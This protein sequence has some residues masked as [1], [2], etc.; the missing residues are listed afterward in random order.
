MKTFITDD[1]LLYNDTARELFHDTAKHLPI[2]DYHNHLNQHEIL[3]DKNYNNIAEIWLGEDHYKWRAMR[4]NGIDE[5]Y[6]TGDKSDYDKF[7]A[8][9][10]TVPMAFGNPLYHWT[11]LELL[12]YFE[13]AELLDEKS[14]PAIWEEA[15]QKLAT[16]EMSVRSLLK[17]MNVEFVGTTDDPVDDLASHKKLHDE[18]FEITVSPSF[19]PDKGINIERDEYL[20]WLDQLREVTNSS[21]D[22]YDQFLAAL[23]ERVD[24]FDEHGCR[25]SDHGIEVIFYAEATKNEVEAIFQK[26][27][28]GEALTPQ[29]IE[30]YKTYTLVSLGEM[31]A[32]KGW[33]MQL[34]MSPLRNNNTR[35]FS[36]IGPDTGF[37]SIG[38]VR[39]AEKLANLLDALDAKDKLPKT[40]LYS[41]N[42]NDNDVLA[43]MAGNFQSA[44]VPGKVQLGTAWW[45]NDTIDGMEKQ[46]KSLANIG[47]ISNFIGMLTD[48]RSFLSFPRH[49]Y[50]RRV[51]CNLLGTWV[52]E[53]K[54]PR[55]MDLLKKYVRGICYENAVRY[56]NI[57]K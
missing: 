8:W 51:L 43:A 6:I 46:M 22:N 52:E 53:Q 19:R 15:N 56:F 48:S 38:D 49:E 11:H 1:F 45:F 23:A 13:I 55:D 14:A 20:S 42:A 36:K 34:H 33:A 26:R 2:I 10:K 5:A 44:E 24:Y 40:I 4:A 37:D 35:M 50:F 47:L 32:E 30:Q 27:L 16:K 41:L 39:I 29:E 28:N 7:L 9:A 25:S 57:E 31:Y 12:R 18:G 3:A 54:V 17:K 21:I